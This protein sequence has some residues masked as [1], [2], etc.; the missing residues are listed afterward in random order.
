MLL[1]ALVWS[2]G[3]L[4]DFVT[5][6]LVPF[7]DSIRSWTIP[8]SPSTLAEPSNPTATQAS[9]SVHETLFNTLYWAPVAGL[10]TMVQEAPVRTSIR[11]CCTPPASV[12]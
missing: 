12:E 3:G 10:A 9:G 1:S 6:Q 11:A 8:T 2:P 5:V 7:H 4:P